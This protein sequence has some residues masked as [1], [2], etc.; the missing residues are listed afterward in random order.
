MVAGAEGLLE[1]IFITSE[2][3]L[4]MDNNNFDLLVS[5]LDKVSK[6][7]QGIR[8]LCPVHGSKGLTL[9]VTP[10][11]GGYIVAHCFSCGAGGPDLTKAL[12]LPVSIL[13]PE[14]DYRP[15]TITKDMKRKNIEDGFIQQ[16]AKDA[17]TLDDVRAVNRSVERSKGYEQK[18]AEAGE[19]VPTDHLA[20]KPFETIFDMALEKSPALRESIIENHWDGVAQRAEFWL[21]RQ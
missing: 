7:G 16:I 13:F 9:S 18:M 21:K 2:T 5:K 3:I 19:E 12:G 10:K 20:L 17:E 15:P 1:T 8:A 11:D 14:D 4:I 6:S